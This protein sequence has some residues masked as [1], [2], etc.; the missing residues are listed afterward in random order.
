MFEK[1]RNNSLK[2]YRL[3]LSHYLSESG[4]SWDAMCK[5]TKTKLELIS[6]PD[7]YRFFEKVTRGTKGTSILEVDFEYPEELQEL[8]NDYPLTPDKIEIKKEMSEYQLCWLT[9]LIKNS[10]CFAMKTYNFT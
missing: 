9:F 10:M 2:N 1:F 5:M 4:L 8:H 3:C 7:M 6:D